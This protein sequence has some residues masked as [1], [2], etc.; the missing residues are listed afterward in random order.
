MPRDTQSDMAPEVRNTARVEPEYQLKCRW[1]FRAACI[2]SEQLL[3]AV[4]KFEW[5]NNMYTITAICNEL[6]MI[7]GVTRQVLPH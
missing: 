4:L 1:L 7:V 6:F 3:K 5:C 2:N